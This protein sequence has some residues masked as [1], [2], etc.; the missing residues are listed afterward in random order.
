VSIAPSPCLKSGTETKGATQEAAEAEKKQCLQVNQPQKLLHGH[1][2]NGS[3]YMHRGNTWFTDIVRVLCIG[4]GDEAFPQTCGLFFYN[5][6]W[7]KLFLC[8]ETVCG[9]QNAGVDEHSRVSCVQRVV[10]G[11]LREAG[12]GSPAVVHAE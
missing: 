8:L 3:K 12:G 5:R 2:S 9:L 7:A 10:F 6:K 11:S 4:P 1:P